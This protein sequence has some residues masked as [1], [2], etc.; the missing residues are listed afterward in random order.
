MLII[1]NM[2]FTVKQQNILFGTRVSEDR[3]LS[4]MCLHV[5]NRNL[6]DLLPVTTYFV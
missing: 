5:D 2:G 4:K 6:A 3:I 1:L